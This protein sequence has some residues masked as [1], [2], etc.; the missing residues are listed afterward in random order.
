MT[1]DTTDGL[2]PFVEQH[3]PKEPP[4]GRTTI[5]MFYLRYVLEHMGDFSNTALLL[6]HFGGIPV[7]DDGEITT[8]QEA[9]RVIEIAPPM[10]KSGLPFFHDFPIHDEP[11][12]SLNDG[13][14]AILREGDELTLI[15]GNANHTTQT[16][17]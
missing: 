17:A 7:D 15:V 4:E 11:P 14:R 8:K 1:D 9:T 6:A 2:D 13:E 12:D 10:E 16:D 3:L 5:G